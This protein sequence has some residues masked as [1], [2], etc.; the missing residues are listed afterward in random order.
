MKIIRFRKDV[1]LFILTGM[2]IF[3][4]VMIFYPNT[5]EAS[6]IRLAGEDRY[7]TA[8]AISRQGWQSSDY[9]LIVRGDDF[10][11]ALCAGPL[12]GKYKAPILFT[13]KYS[14]NPYTLQELQRLKVKNV[15][16]IGGY[17]VISGYIDQNLY[18]A[19]ILKVERIYGKDRYETSVEIAK[20]LGSKEIAL[21]NARQ[22]ADALSVSAVAAVK[23]FSILLTPP[24]SLPEVVRQH[25]T[26]YRIE[27]AYLIGGEEVIS[28]EIEKQLRAPVRLA[29]E[30]RYETNAAILDKFAGDLDFQRIMVAAG[31]GKSTYTDSL[32]GVALAARTNSPLILSGRKLADST[33]S[34]LEKKISV[35]SKMIILGGIQAIPPSVEEELSQCIDRV[36]HSVFQQMGTYGPSEGTTTISG[37]LVINYPGIIVQ[38]TVIEGDLLLRERI[39]S[40]SVELNNVTV[41]G[42]TTIRGGGSS[43]IIGENF[44][45][46]EVIIDSPYNRNTV[47]Y[48]TGKS[49]VDSVQI[50]TAVT[51]DISENT[52][53]GISEVTILEGKE[54]ILRGNFTKII[55]KANGF[56][57]RLEEAEIKTLDA[58]AGGY[59]YGSGSIATA[60]INSNGVVIN[61]YPAVTVVGEGYE[62]LVAGQLLSEGTTKYTPPVVPKSI[63]ISN[64]TVTAGNGQ[65]SFTFPAPTGATSVILKQSTNGSTWVNAST[66][67]LNANSTSATAVGLVNGTLYYFKLV[68]SGGSRAGESNTVTAT[69]VNP[70]DD[71]EGTAGDGQ[72][73]F[74][75]SQPVGAGSVVLKQSVDNGSTWTDSTVDVPLTADSTSALATGLTNGQT[76]QFKLVVTGGP[77]AGDSNIETVFLPEP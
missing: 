56:I 42:R 44:T 40:G 17:G 35:A 9:A 24:D 22:Y 19:G 48:L 36:N 53:G 25:L 43:G 51:L 6:D 72:V 13:E 18:S 66:G 34:F 46:K 61:F 29:G 49:K 60:N 41:K 3:Q 45:S 65:A 32:A 38:N 27:R 10:A 30:N 71:L 76:Y 75:F 70:I 58:G 11:D 52:S 68:V 7:R 23:G 64:L 54:V 5:A 39:G 15:V 28:K 77:R 12:A 62:V 37:S 1:L 69:P 8:V 33:K 2:V 31:E 4:L 73:S 74:T 47:L 16:I 57:L 50:E 59:I 55:S 14:L 21:A 63:P 20:R 67:S 26:N